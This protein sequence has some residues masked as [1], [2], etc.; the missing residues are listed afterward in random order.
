MRNAWFAIIDLALA[1]FSLGGC[2][3][4]RR[5]LRKY[6]SYMGKAWAGFGHLLLSLFALCGVASLAGVVAA[7]AIGAK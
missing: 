2:L 5:T 4:V 1:A 3:Y 6:R 7:V